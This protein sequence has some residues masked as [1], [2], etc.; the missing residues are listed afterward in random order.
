M[1][2]VYLSYWTGDLYL[3]EDDRWFIFK[4]I[5]TSD[6]EKLKMLSCHQIFYILNRF[7]LVAVSE[8]ELFTS[9]VNCGGL[10][11]SPDFVRCKSYCSRIKI[12]HGL[13][14]TVTK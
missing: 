1:R 5:L 6:L 13:C 2:P 3:N 4:S 8:I 7:G 12:K 11:F 14:G 10:L 9:D